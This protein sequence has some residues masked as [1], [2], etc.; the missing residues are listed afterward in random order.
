MEHILI[1]RINQTV[2]FDE[3]WQ[4][5][6]QQITPR[7][8][9]II[10]KLSHYSW[11]THLR[12][13]ATHLWPCWRKW[14]FRRKNP[15]PTLDGPQQWRMPYIAIKPPPKWLLFLFFVCI[16]FVTEILQP[17]IH[18][19]ASDKSHYNSHRGYITRSRWVIVRHMW[20]MKM[21]IFLCAVKFCDKNVLK[22]I[23]FWL[24]R[25]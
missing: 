24:V 7:I 22:E 14:S 16:I 19:S 17:G 2:R 23:M 4:K 9:N 8:H 13:K 1:E 3:H 25:G 5:K 10:H 12:I 11:T 15:Y 20:L 21:E 6:A 18:Q